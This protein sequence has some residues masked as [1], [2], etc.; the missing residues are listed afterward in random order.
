MRGFLVSIEYEVANI[1]GYCKSLRYRPRS[2][3]Q[4]HYPV[5]QIIEL[6]QKQAIQLGRDL[7][8]EKL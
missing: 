8:K 1:R 4:Y 7:E 5:N 3:P 6:T 2:R